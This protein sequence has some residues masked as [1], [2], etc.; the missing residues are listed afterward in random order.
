MA[1]VGNKALSAAQRA[2]ILEVAA[3]HGA[4]NVRLFGSRVREI[5]GRESDIDLLVDMRPGQSLL[6]LIAIEQDLEDKLAIRVDVLT[7]AGLSPY[8]REQVLHEVVPL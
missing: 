5:T 3:S 7:E 4:I 8:M 1:V 6:D 2:V